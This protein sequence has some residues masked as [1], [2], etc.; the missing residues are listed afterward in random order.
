MALI[1]ASLLPVG[2]GLAG[3]GYLVAAILL[4]A[5]FLGFGIAFAADRSRKRATRLFRASIIYLPILLGILVLA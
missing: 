1:V 5:G 4:G 2:F 3:N